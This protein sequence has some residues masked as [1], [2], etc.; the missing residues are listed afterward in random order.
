MSAVMRQ[1]VKRVML[2]QSVAAV[3]N[4]ALLRDRKSTR[5]NSSHQ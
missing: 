4:A 1:K 3:R 2:K 5:L